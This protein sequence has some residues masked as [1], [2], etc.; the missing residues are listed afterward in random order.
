MY[1]EYQGQKQ[2]GELLAV[3]IYSPQNYK[4][5]FVDFSDKIQ[6]QFGLE[7]VGTTYGQQ[8]AFSFDLILEKIEYPGLTKIKKLCLAVSLLGD[9]YAIFGMDQTLVIDDQKPYPSH[10]YATNA[11][12]LSPY[13]EFEQPFLNLKKAVQ[14]RYPDH[15]QI[16]FS[17]LTTYIDG[18]FGKFDLIHECMVYNALFNQ[19]LTNNYMLKIR[20]DQHFGYNEWLKGGVEVMEMKSVEVIVVPPPPIPPPAVI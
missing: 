15:K 17:I 20:G 12:T 16:P 6:E 8:P 11:V 18:L 4:E 19:Q 1:H 10:Y 3:N 9:F 2:L 7:L 13:K 14:E 5:R